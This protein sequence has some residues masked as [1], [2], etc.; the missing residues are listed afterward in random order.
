[1]HI[2]FQNC[3]AQCTLTGCELNGNIPVKVN[4]R[5]LLKCTGQT[6]AQTLH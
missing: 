1:L 3:Y 4:V 6:F 5:R 2:N